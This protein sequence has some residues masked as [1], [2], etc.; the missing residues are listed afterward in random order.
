MDIQ[1][2]S[3]R[4][5]LATDSVGERAEESSADSFLQLR[6]NPTQVADYLIMF[7]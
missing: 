3:S 5:I 2:K 6:R 4:A 1:I 7:C